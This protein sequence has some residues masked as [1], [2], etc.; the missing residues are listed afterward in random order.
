MAY[1]SSSGRQTDGGVMMSDR[2]QN[3]PILAARD[4]YSVAAFVGN[5]TQNDIE[6][7]EF[8]IEADT[9]RCCYKRNEKFSFFSNLVL[10]VKTKA[11]CC[12]PKAYM[13]LSVP[14]HRVR[15]VTVEHETRDARYNFIWGMIYALAALAYIVFAINMDNGSD[16]YGNII[17]LPPPHHMGP[18]GHHHVRLSLVLPLAAAA[19]MQHAQTHS[20]GRHR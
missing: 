10:I 9:K 18:R 11:C 5:T 17:G 16:P 4:E 14:R 6:Q 13:H 15:A 19:Q 20:V 2:S 12:Y 1:N 8:V 3:K 7:P